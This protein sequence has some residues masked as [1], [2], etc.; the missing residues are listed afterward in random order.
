MTLGS[1]WIALL[2]PV[3]AASGWLAAKKHDGRKSGG[4]QSAAHGLTQAY[5]RSLNYLLDDKTDKAIATVA[6][7][8]EQ[9]EEPLETQIVLGNLFRRRG[10]VEKAIELHEKLVKSTDLG[11]AHQCKARYELGVDYLRAGLLDR[12]EGIFLALAETR[13]HR[14][15]SLQLL[16]QLYQQQRDWQKAIS[17]IRELRPIA[18]PLHGETAAHFYCELAEE[19]MTRHR[20]KDARDFLAKALQDDAGS[21][22]ASIVK[23]RLELGNGEYLQALQSFK[24]VELQNPAYMAVVLPLISLCW[25]RLGNERELIEY[26]D[27][28]F[29]DFGIVSAAVERAERLK[30]TFGSGYAVD[31]LVPILESQPEPLALARALTLIVEDDPAAHDGLRR[32]CALLKA[33]MEGREQFQCDQCGFG[34]SDL[35]WRCPSCQHWDSVK[36][37][38]SFSALPIPASD[39]ELER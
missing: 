18:K 39:R 10:E 34:A 38:G 8:L 1:E 17:C 4:A 36:P 12:A 27:H 15:A 7:I 35:Y 22:R 20:L 2:L 21:V 19:A 14:K 11:P 32:I 26:L 9:D 30:S 25:V 33:L 6:V 23:G 29:E 13:T 16:L 24:A 28:L 3:A 37:T 31:Y 5:R